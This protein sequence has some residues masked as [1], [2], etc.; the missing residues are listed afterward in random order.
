MDKYFNQYENLAKSDLSLTE[1]V[2]RH[3]HQSTSEKRIFNDIKRK[4]SNLNKVNLTIC[5]IGCGCGRVV[6]DLINLASVNHNTLTLIDAKS[7]LDRVEDKSFIEK[8][9]GEF[10]GNVD[11]M[12]NKKFDAMIV[13]SV[14]QYVFSDGN[15]YKFLDQCVDMLK[16]N[17]QLLI[18]DIP[19]LSKKIRFLNTD[20]GI[21]LHKKTSKTNPKLSK[22]FNQ[23]ALE[24]TF[25]LSILARYRG[26]GFEVYLLPQPKNLPFSYTREDIL[27]VKGGITNEKRSNME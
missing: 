9:P 11:I 20:F 22:M 2:G 25:I 26:M 3:P 18:G 19:N 13:Y 27:I 4:I 12:T 10:P 6:D 23:L 7:M 17:G 21:D 8:I 15:V 5:D 16:Y 24:D 1:I 14:I